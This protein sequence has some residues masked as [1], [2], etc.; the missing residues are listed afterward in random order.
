MPG[1]FPTIHFLDLNPPQREYSAG[2]NGRTLADM[3]LNIFEYWPIVL[4]VDLELTTAA[5][6]KVHLVLIH[7]E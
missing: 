3:F 1:L 4:K 6:S 5:P 2:M 7:S